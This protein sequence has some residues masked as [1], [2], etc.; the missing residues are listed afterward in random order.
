MPAVTVYTRPMCGYCATIT[1]E[2]AQ[3]GIAFEA[4]DIW[5]DRSQAEVVRE[6]NDGDEL[7]P[8]VRV[9]TRFFANPSIEELLAVIGRR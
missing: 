9:G 5:A 1:Q 7:V 6:A 3:R 8:T 2:L 4:V